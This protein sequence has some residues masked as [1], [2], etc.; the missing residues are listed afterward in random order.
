[1]GPGART[2]LQVFC[3]FGGCT[4]PT[5]T[6]NGGGG[7]GADGGPGGRRR[8]GSRFSGSPGGDLRPHQRLELGAHGGVGEIWVLALG[9]SWSIFGAGLRGKNR[10]PFCN[11]LKHG[12]FFNTKIKGNHHLQGNVQVY[13][14]FLWVS[15]RLQQ[16][17]FKND[18]AKC[19][20]K[21]DHQ[22]LDRRLTRPWFHLP[23]QT[24]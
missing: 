1:M 13:N 6:Q 5:Q 10:S 3:R 15:E 16:E 21:L 14:L 8:Y 22:E 4:H 20:S 24:I 17:T 11:P 18:N 12:G 9:H 19:G 7:V 2:V 23:G